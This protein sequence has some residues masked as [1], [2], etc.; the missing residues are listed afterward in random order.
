MKIRWDIAGTERQRSLL[1]QL[2]RV[3]TKITRIWADVQRDGS[4]GEYRWRP[5][6]KFHNSILRTTLQSLADPAAG[7]PCSNAA[8]IGECKT[9]TQSAILVL[10]ID[11]KAVATRRIPAIYKPRSNPYLSTNPNPN[12]TSI[13]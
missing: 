10:F 11:C 13:L 9:W 12:P 5:V 2:S 7:V 3:E 8:N 6:R 1:L 4:P